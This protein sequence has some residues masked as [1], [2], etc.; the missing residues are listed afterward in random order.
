MHDDE[1]EIDEA[2]ARRLLRTQF[3]ELAGLAVRAVDSTGTVN[4]IFR[5]GEQLCMRL[6]RVKAGEADLVHE[7]CWLPRLAGTLALEV[8]R[9][10]AAG[11][12]GEGYP[13]RWAVL[14]WIQGETFS[15]ERVVD[16]AAAAAGLAHFVRSLRALDPAGGA[17]SGRRPLAELDGMTRAAI[18]AAGELVDAARAMKAWARSLDAPA[19]EGPPVWRHCDLLPP[20]LLMTEGRLTAVID[21]GSVGVGDPAADVIAAWSVF[22][23]A[24]RE[25]FRSELAV[26]DA[27]WVRA[28]GYA[29]H[30]AVLIIPYYR[31]TN[32]RF[33]EMARRTV[34]EVIVDDSPAI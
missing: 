27:T 2:L 3:P 11:E 7:L 13:F 8:P 23:A 16:E 17:P 26:D 19:W 15:V 20:N 22:G 29:L 30:Q 34:N 18:A 14:G 4:A 25:R 21:F 28:R 24:G 33:V 9:P 6:P 32:P 10:V 5:L 1:V 12:P 31:E